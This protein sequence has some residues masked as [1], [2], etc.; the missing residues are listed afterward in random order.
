MADNLSNILDSTSSS[1][2]GLS[3]NGESKAHL[4]EI[5]KW[6]KFL[7]ILGFIFVGFMVLIA[8]FMGTVFSSLGADLP[9]PGI[10]FTFMY[11][12]IA[13]LYFFPILYLFKFSSA[14]KTALASDN[15]Q[16]LAE[17]F[18]NLKS[19]YK[20]IGILSIIVLGLYALGFF[21]G[22]LGGLSQGF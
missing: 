14:L 12:V 21:L 9:L 17:A 3:I 20:F 11:L 8:L 13:A 22:L 2:G 18:G 19:H 7:S 10:L 1:G 5:K 6:V 4:D 15:E 16:A